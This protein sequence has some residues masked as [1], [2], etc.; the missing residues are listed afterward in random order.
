MPHSAPRALTDTHTKF[1]MSFERFLY[2]SRRRCP[3]GRRIEA[4]AAPRVFVGAPIATKKPGSQVFGTAV[5]LLAQKKNVVGIFCRSF[6][7]S[8]PGFHPRV[9]WRSWSWTSLWSTR[10]RPPSRTTLDVQILGQPSG[11]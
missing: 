8:C 7:E 9:L 6:P 3:G 11:A 4:T 2:S 10:T 5:V 1:L